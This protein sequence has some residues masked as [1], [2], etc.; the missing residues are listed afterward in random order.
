MLPSGSYKVEASNIIIYIYF[1]YLLNFFFF[2]GK[3]SKMGKYFVCCKYGTVHKMLI[4][5]GT[6][7]TQNQNLF[8]KY[9]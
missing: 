9:V 7:S 5:I 3:S 6:H 2:F 1:I 4:L 8:H